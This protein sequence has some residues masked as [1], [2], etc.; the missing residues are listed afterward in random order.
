GAIADQLK[1]QFDVALDKKKIHM[2]H[3]I[4]TLGD[5]EVELRLHQDVVTKL[6]LRVESSTPLPPPVEVSADRRDERRDGRRTEKR[7][8]RVEPAAA[9]AP[10]EEKAA[11]PQK[12]EKAEKV[13]KA[14]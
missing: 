11:K 12:A 9:A 13:E 2:E 1:T 4:R 7:G 8:H 5:H 3:P 10:V 6:K 14:E